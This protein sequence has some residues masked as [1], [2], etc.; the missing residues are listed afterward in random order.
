M[1]KKYRCNKENGVTVAF[2]DVNG[3]EYNKNS[4]EG[5]VRTKLGVYASAAVDNMLAWAFEENALFLSYRRLLGLRGTA[6][7]KDGD[8]YNEYVGKDIAGANLDM[9]YHRDMSNDYAKVIKRLNRLLNVLNEL[10]D[11]HDNKVNNIVADM[12]KMYRE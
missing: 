3:A 7:C 2:Y 11:F 6:T 1:R 8:E 12:K 10:K 4:L 5:E 9:K